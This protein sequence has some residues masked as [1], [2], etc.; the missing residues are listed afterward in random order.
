[1][2]TKVLVLCLFLICSLFHENSAVNSGCNEPIT[3]GPCRASIPR[4]AFDGSKCIKFTYGGCQGNGNNFM[5]KEECE[6]ACSGSY[7]DAYKAHWFKALT[8]SIS[9]GGEVQTTSDPQILMS[10]RL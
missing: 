6:N 3:V 8:K 7:I 4:W 9:S 1:M 2:K 10:R 5:T